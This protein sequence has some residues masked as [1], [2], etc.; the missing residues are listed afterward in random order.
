MSLT[1]DSP[2]IITSMMTTLIETTTEET[3]TTTTSTLFTNMT[4]SD[5]NYID[6]EKS[7]S[8]YYTNKTGFFI[9]DYEG[10]PE[11]LLINIVAF[12][13]LLVIFTFLRK[14]GDYG[15]FGLMKADEEK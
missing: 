6:I 8:E 7:C 9:K 11:N 5:S 12:I 2:S 14:I 15:R 10:I 4:T 13:G 3:S 1:T